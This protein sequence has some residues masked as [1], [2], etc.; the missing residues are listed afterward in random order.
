MKLKAGDR[1]FSQRFGNGTVIDPPDEMIDG[2][3]A[4]QFDNP[5][6]RLHGK[7]EGIIPLSYLKG[8]PDYTTWFYMDDGDDHNHADGSS[9][10]MIT[11]I[12]E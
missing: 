1:V 8:R 10:D 3:I 9:F 7:H 2:A 11:L 5:D 6:R 12:E 4:V